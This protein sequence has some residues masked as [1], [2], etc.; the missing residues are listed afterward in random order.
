MTPSGID[1][2]N[3]Q[4]VAQCLNHCATACAGYKRTYEVFMKTVLP[5]NIAIVLLFVKCK[6]PGLCNNDVCE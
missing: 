4:F 3:F 1:P 2:A 5:G 6:A